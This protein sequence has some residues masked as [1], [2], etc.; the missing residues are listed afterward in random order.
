V[1]AFGNVVRIS[2]DVANSREVTCTAGGIA[3][4][5]DI[6]VARSLK[7]VA[8]GFVAGFVARDVVGGAVDDAGGVATTLGGVVARLATPALPFAAKLL[9]DVRPAAPPVIVAIRAIIDDRRCGRLA[10]AALL[11]A[12][13]SE[14]GGRPALPNALV[15]F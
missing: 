9:L 7:A 10:S 15:T 12:T 8:S 14:L 11:I 2:I 4:V 1:A 3:G 13:P 5:A 6:D